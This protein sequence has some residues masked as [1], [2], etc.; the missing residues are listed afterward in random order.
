MNAAMLFL[1]MAGTPAP[2]ADVARERRAR[3]QIERS[4]GSASVRIVRSFR[5]TREAF[6][7]TVPG[8]LKRKAWLTDR[9]GERRQAE[10]IEFE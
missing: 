5:L 6:D 3:P 4:T 2:V 7:G 9:D 10:L 8:A 1:A